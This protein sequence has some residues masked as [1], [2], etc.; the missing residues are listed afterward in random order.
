MTSCKVPPISHSMFDWSVGETARC[1]VAEMRHSSIDHCKNGMLY[2]NG[3][4][5]LFGRGIGPLLLYIV[6]S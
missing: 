3:T 6:Q 4:G 2:G 5:S 1:T